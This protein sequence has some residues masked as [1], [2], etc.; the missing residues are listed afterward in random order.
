MEFRPALKS[1]E[2]STA[3]FIDNINK[4]TINKMMFSKIFDV[5]FGLSF[6]L[7]NYKAS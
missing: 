5:C 4:N 2:C 6:I 3:S 1:S 7:I